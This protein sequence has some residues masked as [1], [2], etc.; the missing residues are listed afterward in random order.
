MF[1]EA[2]ISSGVSLKK[3]NYFGVSLKSLSFTHFFVVIYYL[4]GTMSKTSLTACLME[5]CQ[6][7]RIK[8]SNRAVTQLA[9]ESFRHMRDSL[10]AEGRFAYPGFGVLKVR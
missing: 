10:I 7:N 8:I 3:E 9:D 6:A 4:E 2:V 5:F 1:S